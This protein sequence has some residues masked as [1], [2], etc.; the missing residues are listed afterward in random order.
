MAL[1]SDTLCSAR[2][3]NEGWLL[4]HHLLATSFVYGGNVEKMEHCRRTTKSLLSHALATVVNNFLP[5]IQAP[6][7]GFAT[8][9]PK[10]RGKRYRNR[11]TFCYVGDGYLV[12]I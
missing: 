12:V 9:S 2:K 8:Y 11:S 1:V 3:S 7:R 5:A 6:F 10:V 4:Q